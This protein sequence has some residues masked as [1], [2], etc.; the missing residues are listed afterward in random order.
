[1]YAS[2][3]IFYRKSSCNKK[4][5]VATEK[6]KPCLEPEFFFK[7]KKKEDRGKRRG[8]NRN[9]VQDAREA[10]TAT[11]TAK[12]SRHLISSPFVKSFQNQS[13]AIYI[14]SI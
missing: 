13:S 6:T 12:P 11:V 2:L 7:D 9:F 4:E 3:F 8:S 14:W 10:T 5:S 1:L